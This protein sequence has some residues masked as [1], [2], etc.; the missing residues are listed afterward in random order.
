MKDIFGNIRLHK[1]I[2]MTYE[3]AMQLSL[4]VKWKTS[5]CGDKHCWCR[6]V[7]PI[8]P[9]PYTF[10]DRTVDYLIIPSGAIGKEVAEHIVL[11]HNSYL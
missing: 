4:Q 7:E 11:I 2:T 3:K 1:R 6:V 5:N 10:D 8:E 9:I